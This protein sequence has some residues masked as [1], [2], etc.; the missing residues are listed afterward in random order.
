M[1][2]FGSLIRRPRREIRG[3]STMR[4]EVGSIPGQQTQHPVTVFQ[5]GL[6]PRALRPARTVLR[7]A[8]FTRACPN[9]KNKKII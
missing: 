7:P 9:K 4:G 3:T 5:L 6:F 2:Y 8:R 1:R